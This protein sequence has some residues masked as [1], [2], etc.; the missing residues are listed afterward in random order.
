M[1]SILNQDYKNF[2]LIFY[3]NNSNDS[4]ASL[5]INKIP[6]LKYYRSNKKENLGTVRQNALDLVNGEY[7]AFLD[8]DDIW[9]SEHL[10]IAVNFLENN[11]DFNLT[12]NNV[13]LISNKK[14]IIKKKI[15]NNLKPSGKIFR[16]LLSSYFLTIVTVVIRTRFLRDNNLNFN[17]K[18]DYINDVDLFTRISYLTNIKYL[19]K[20]NC[21]SKNSK[22]DLLVKIFFISQRA[23]KLFK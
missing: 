13:S 15:F 2:E 16:E 21:K 9:L 23:L 8:C 19:N 1:N 5:A 7:V 3:D 6:D 22:I 18:Y 20:N 4:S 11:L 14:K 10:L 17:K 12:Y